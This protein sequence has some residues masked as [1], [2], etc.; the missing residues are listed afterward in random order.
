MK[1]K[2]SALYSF[3]LAATFLIVFCT[4]AQAADI[5]L[6]LVAYWR[7]DGLDGSTVPDETSNNN[8]Q[9]VV[10]VTGGN[11]V[12][13]QFGN[14]VSL[15]GSSTYMTNVHSTDPSLSGLP[16]YKAGSYTI[17][18]WVK[19]AAQ[20]AKYLFSEGYT[21]SQAPLFIL[22]TG[23]VAANNNKLDVIIRPDAGTALVD[24]RVSTAVVFDDT[25]H[26][27]AWVDD[28]GT[29]RLYIDGVL[30]S[31]NFNYTPSSAFTFNNTAIGTLFRSAVSTGAIFT[32]LIDD[33][34]VW[35]RA[36]SADEV[37]E[38]RTNSIQT[39]IPLFP[40]VIVADPTGSTNRLGDRIVLNAVAEGA[41]PIAFQWLK[42][43]VVIPGATGSSLTL[44]NLV[45]ADSGNYALRVSNAAGTNTSAAATLLVL[46]D[47][48]PNLQQGIVSYWPSDEQLE[49]E[50]AVAYLTDVY[51]RNDFKIVSANLYLDLIPGVQGNAASFNGVEQFTYREGGFP[52]YST[53]AYSL[54][55]WVRADGS[56][57]VDR[58]LFAE[59]ALNNN[60][61][62]FS[63][64]TATGSNGTLRVLI[65]DAAGVPI[66]DRH[67][68][69]VPLD[70]NWHHIAWTDLNG[71]GRLY[72]DGVLDE[73]SFFYTRR[74]LTLNTTTL[75]G[76][77]RA[78]GSNN[79]FT[80]AIDE[81]GAWNRILSL[82]EIQEVLDTGIPAATA[83]S[84]PIITLDPASQS[85]LTRG[86]VTFTFAASGTGPLFP[87]WRKGG[88]PLPG[89]TNTTLVLSN[90]TAADAGTFDVVV[91]NSV[92]SVTSQVATLT[93]TTR[94]VTTELKVDFNNVG[95]DNAP[96]NTQPGFTAF[97]MPIPVGTG[98]FTSLIGGAE[99]TVSSIGGISLQSRR[100]TVPLNNGAFTEEQLLRDF[101]FS[102]DS[103]IGQG[104]QVRIDYLEPNQPYDLTIWSYDNANS[105]RFSDW[106][107]NGNVLTNGYTFTGA[108]LPTDNL[109]YRFSFPVT[110][111]AQGSIVIQGLRSPTAASAN[112]VFL[113]ALQLTAAQSL[114][115]GRIDLDSPATLRLTVNGITAGATYVVEE[116]IN[117]SDAGW[118]E[119]VGAVFGA[120]N[121]D[122]VEVTIPRPATATRFYHVV[123]VPAP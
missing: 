20:T 77:L 13:G 50:Q 31:A 34:A 80:G 38:V 86:Q 39:P 55:M 116:K 109:M 12:P 82:T 17:T 15:N 9:T 113:N 45:V 123:E 96:A 30:D 108:T 120:P 70:S 33:V 83:D 51:G 56:N 94:A 25:W 6:G 46:P 62:I 59:T 112:N 65:R 57:Q 40:A 111:D 121:G 72:I 11:F 18:M 24:H 99:V 49:D 110:A 7:M 84:A 81:I 1:R 52:T 43:D 88:A 3:C 37:Q 106:S 60:N 22:Q 19:G 104:L 93:I 27:V 64:G 10:N 114:R 54:T 66:L 29:V 4:T 79:L 107:A 97:A 8:D 95:V 71:Q 102:P 63:L 69:R 89:Q 73:T 35:K 26:H 87:Q 61:T 90:V 47:A 36:L 115:V 105:A 119:V 53:P 118:T 74:P 117:L 78:T 2:H 101:I 98:P 42:D 32:G 23:Q 100:R 5:R 67:S 41:T 85:A 21:A 68:T 28:N 58:K 16:V 91:T 103:A 122:T 14:A 75:G 92:G 48:P 44:S 76:L